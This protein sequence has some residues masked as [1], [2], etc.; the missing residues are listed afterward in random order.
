MKYK[1]Y[2]TDEDIKESSTSIIEVRKNTSMKTVVLKAVERHVNCFNYD[3]LEFMREVKS[4]HKESDELDEFTES[5]KQDLDLSIHVV[6]LNNHR[7]YNKDKDEYTTSYEEGKDSYE[8]AW[9]GQ[10]NEEDGEQ[11]F[12]KYLPDFDTVV[13]H[14]NELTSEE[15]FLEDWEIEEE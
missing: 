9:R 13:E 10:L 14:G 5:L 15:W 12:D 2:V 3:Q 11:D 6:D 1:V 4:L 7:Y 8:R